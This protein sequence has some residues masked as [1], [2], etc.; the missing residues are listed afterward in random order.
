MTSTLDIFTTIS[1]ELSPVHLDQVAGG[2]MMADII[3][4]GPC[5]PPPYDVDV[6]FL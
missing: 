6:V 2:R 1:T 4:S 5:F 3:V